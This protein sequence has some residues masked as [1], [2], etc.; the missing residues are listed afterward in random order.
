MDGLLTEVPGRAFHHG[1]DT[2]KNCH[3]HVKI[4]LLGV[5]MLR[6]GFREAENT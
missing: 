2:E 5:Q 1:Q 3:P 4:S 6:V